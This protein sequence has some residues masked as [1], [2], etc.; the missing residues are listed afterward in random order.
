MPSPLCLCPITYIL[1]THQAKE[2]AAPQLVL[3]A[4]NAEPGYTPEQLELSEKPVKWLVDELMLADPRLTL[5]RSLM[6]LRREKLAGM[7]LRAWA[8]N[9]SEESERRRA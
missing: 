3:P 8:A 6:R 2:P 5:R 9:D 4:I 1:S 7:L